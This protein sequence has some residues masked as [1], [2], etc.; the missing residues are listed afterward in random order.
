VGQ[1]AAEQREQHWELGLRCKAVSSHQLGVVSNCPKAQSFQRAQD[2]HLNSIQP[3]NI[4][5]SILVAAPLSML[6]K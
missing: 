6:E 3:T 5:F 1:G 4:L 2:H